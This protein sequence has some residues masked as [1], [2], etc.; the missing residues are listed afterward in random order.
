MRKP[1]RR[2]RQLTQRQFSMLSELAVTGAISP[3]NLTTVARALSAPSLSEITAAGGSAAPPPG[4]S[5]AQPPEPSPRAPVTPPW[6]SLPAL[7]SSP[8]P[9]TLPGA[10]PAPAPQRRG[11]RRRGS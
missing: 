6:E 11:R 2:S 5:R 3:A 1:R 9:L 10:A 8:P 7:G 4:A